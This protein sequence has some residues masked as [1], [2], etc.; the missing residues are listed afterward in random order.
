MKVL[1]ISI[2]LYPN[3]LCKEWNGFESNEPLMD[4]SMLSG[5]LQRKGAKICLQ[6]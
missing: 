2:C 1:L 3:A 5:L 6:L 4:A